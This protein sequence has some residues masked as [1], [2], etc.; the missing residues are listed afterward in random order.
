MTRLFK[1]SI[2][3]SPGQEA[4]SKK[5][6]P[7]DFTLRYS[8]HTKFLHQAEALGDELLPNGNFMEF[9]SSFFTSN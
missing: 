4:K 7:S 2:F 1:A 8:S 3:L 6:S 9:L 5:S